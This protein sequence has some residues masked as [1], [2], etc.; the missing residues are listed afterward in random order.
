[1]RSSKSVIK[2]SL[3]KLPEKENLVATIARTLHT[4]T[5]TVKILCE[6]DQATLGAR[7]R[8]RKFGVQMRTQANRTSFRSESRRQD[9]R[10]DHRRCAYDHQ[11]TPASDSQ[12]FTDEVNGHSTRSARS[13]LEAKRRLFSFSVPALR[14]AASDREPKTNLA[15]C[16]S[17]G[18]NTNNIDLM[19][20]NCGRWGHRSLRW[21]H[22]SLPG[23][24]QPG[25]P[26]ATMSPKLTRDSDEV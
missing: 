4:Y 3:R 6:A 12:R 5:N 16:F 1:V 11:R 8:V 15:H 19:M 7:N 9:A 24:I 17:C 20:L 13:D 25:I 14:Q 18:Q 10:H 23:G 21:G 2:E 26:R 22:C